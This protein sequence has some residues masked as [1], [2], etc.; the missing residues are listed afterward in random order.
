MEKSIYLSGFIESYE[1]QKGRIPAE[2]NYRL[3]NAIVLIIAQ[4]SLY[5]S[6][7]RCAE[8]KGT[9]VIYAFAQS[10]RERLGIGCRDPFR[11]VLLPGLYL[12]FCVPNFTDRTKSLFSCGVTAGRQKSIRVPK[13]DACARSIALLKT[14]RSRLCIVNIA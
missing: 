12:D 9:E 5:D 6:L 13:F 11:F 4:R 7:W 1:S 8:G 2:S 3:A 10:P 14:V